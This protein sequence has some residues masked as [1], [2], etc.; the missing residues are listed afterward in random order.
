VDGPRFVQ[1]GS[2][3][4]A[5]AIELRTIAFFLDHGGREAAEARDQPDADHVVIVAD[6]R[7]V[8]CGQGHV[9][10]DA[11]HVTQMAV[12]ENRQGSGLGTAILEAL[13][14]RAVQRAMTRASLEARSH[15][16]GFYRRHGFMELTEPRAIGPTGVP[17]VAM[18]L[19]F[20]PDDG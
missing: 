4:H 10:N 7:V 19:R 14:S 13:L 16:V 11:Y 5:Q 12:V 9:E 2:T 15:A 20:R 18:E 8:A 17:H 3:E 6:G 1:P